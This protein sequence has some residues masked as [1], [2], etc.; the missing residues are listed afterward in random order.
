M[1][2][3]EQIFDTLANS[4]PKHLADLVRILVDYDSANTK[5]GIKLRV[6][7]MILAGDIIL[8]EDRYLKIP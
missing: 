4:G 6:L 8:T 2:I 1:T 5:T 7:S 3:H